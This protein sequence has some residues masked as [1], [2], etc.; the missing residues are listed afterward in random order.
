[1]SVVSA[2]C[3]RPEVDP[4]RIGVMGNSGGGTQTVQLLCADD[5]IKAA[6]PSCFITSLP[7]MLRKIGPQDAEQNLPGQLARGLDHDAYLVARAPIPVL[8]CAKEA[9]FFPIEGTRVVVG[10]ARDVFERLGAGDRIA[11]RV[12]QGRHGWSGELIAASVTFLARHLD[13]RDADVTFE[14]LPVPGP[15][16][17]LVTASGQ[18]L[19]EPDERSIHDI[20]RDERDRLAKARAERPLA[21]RVAL[22]RKLARIPARPDIVPPKVMTTNTTPG[23]LG[24]IS[25]LRLDFAEGY[26]LEATLIDRDRALQTPL[27]IIH[28]EGRSAP[29]ALRGGSAEERARLIVLDP[30]GVGAGAPD[31]ERAFYGAFGRDANDAEI[32][33]LLGHSLVG[34]QARQLIAT[35]LALGDGRPIDVRATGR[36]GIAALHAVATEPGL[37]GRLE[38]VGGLA[39]YAS[40]FDR[41]DIRLYYGSV[42]PGALAAYDLPDLRASLGERVVET[43]R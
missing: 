34:H 16:Q 9:D 31:E 35:A 26:H 10:R 13:G 36:I 40:L 41:D 30:V 20:L 39:S 23:P 2:L 15:K 14:E 5:R 42:V 21:E 4:R 43:A 18:V 17:G 25:T 11:L 8:V 7:T 1:M 32:V 24:K 19:L 28:D 37:F 27:L 38:L 29:A 3:A 22:A 12:D 33:R 6:A